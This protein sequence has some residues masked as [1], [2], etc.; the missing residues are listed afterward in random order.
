VT[1][2]RLARIQRDL[3]LTV[4][5]HGDPGR[6][7]GLAPRA[8]L[9]HW[10]ATRASAARPAPSL[11]IVRR[12]VQGLPGPLYGDLVGFDGRVH[13][14]TVGR[15]NHAGMGSLPALDAIRAGTAGDA[16]PGPDTHGLNGLCVGVSADY[17]PAQGAPPRAQVDAMVRAVA[18][19]IVYHG[20]PVHAVADHA[21]T[22]RRKVDLLDHWPQP[23]VMR[24]LVADLVAAYRGTS[25]AA[26]DPRSWLDM[27][28]EQQVRD[29][30]R[31]EVDRAVAAAQD[32]GRE[33]HR[34]AA[35]RDQHWVR[36]AAFERA[37]AAALDDL[38]A[39]RD[40]AAG[41][42]G[43]SA[44]DVRGLLAEAFKGAGDTLE[45]RG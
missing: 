42:T 24:R 11:G 39:R 43:V 17:H 27:A 5:V 40:G 31:A 7:G 29:I 25:P 26:P 38:L 15:H 12:G 30:V 33:A 41:G 32:A 18:A 21:R 8:V 1:A 10:T 23:T 16:R 44:A 35:A 37:A 14:I 19:R 28:T 34:A 45:E 4:V 22:T 13:L 36:S 6:P 2:A 9:G 3:G 20:L